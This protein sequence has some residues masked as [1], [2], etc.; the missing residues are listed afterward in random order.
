MPG[1]LIA[2]ILLLLAIHA[3]RSL[4]GTED[5]IRILLD[6]G[7]IPA[8]LS[9]L[10]G[11]VQPADLIQQATG[12]GGEAASAIAHYVAAGE[13]APVPFLLTYSLLHGSWSHVLMNCVWLAAFGT[14]VIRRLG[15]LRAVALA[16]ATA[17]GSALAYWIIDPMS[18]QVVIGASGIA[19]GFMGAA[20]TFVFAPGASLL[21]D[22]DHPPRRATGRYAFLVNRNALLFLG[23]WFAVNL[24]MGLVGGPLGLAEGGIAWQAHI[25]GLLA[26]LALFPLLD[27]GP[28]D[29]SRDMAA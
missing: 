14:P 20:A 22:L 7:F 6:G 17:L 3:G 12:E 13:S 4:L 10:L 11:W 23:V 27:R 26:G 24:V 2:F 8:R 25:G 5:E 15:S 1:L 29:R 16:V 28:R 21:A 19:S 18:T 9:L